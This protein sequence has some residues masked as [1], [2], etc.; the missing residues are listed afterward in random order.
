MYL[1]RRGYPFGVLPSM[2]LGYY[3]GSVAL[4]IL[5][6]N[7]R[8]FLWKWGEETKA[9]L[10]PLRTLGG[11]LTGIQLGATKEKR[12]EDFLIPGAGKRGTFF[13]PENF[14]WV[15]FHRRGKVV[16]VEG[17]LDACALSLHLKCVLG[18]LSARVT[19]GQQFGLKRW[20]Q[21]IYCTFDGDEAGEAGYDRFQHFWEMEGILL[22]R[23]SPLT[24]DPQ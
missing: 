11:T 23:V 2:G 19:Q 15:E 22:Q 4:Q 6:R 24:K 1:L 20:A 7:L 3:K 13:Y 16:L 8:G 9:V 14:D 5:S 21:Q 10:Y 18:C 17:C 12:Y